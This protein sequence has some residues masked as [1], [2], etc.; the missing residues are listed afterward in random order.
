MLLTLIG[1]PE[2][3]GGDDCGVCEDGIAKKAIAIIKLRYFIVR[4]QT[5]TEKNPA[6][7]PAFKAAG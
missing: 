3:D 6:N 1:G 7:T 5:R 4:L 2:S